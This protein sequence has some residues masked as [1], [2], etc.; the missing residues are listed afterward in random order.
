MRCCLAVFILAAVMP[1]WIKQWGV[2]AAAVF[3]GLLALWGAVAWWRSR[4]RFRF[5]E[6]EVEPRLGGSHA[7]GIGAVISFGSPAIP[8]AMQRK[9]VPDYMHRA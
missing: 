8:P 4:V 5:P 9:Q 3:G 1:N 7:A 2:V 6:S